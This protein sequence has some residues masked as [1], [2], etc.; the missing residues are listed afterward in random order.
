MEETYPVRTLDISKLLTYPVES[1]E[2]RINDLDLIIKN[3]YICVAANDF[4]IGMVHCL[5]QLNKWLDLKFDMPIQRRFQLAKTV[6]D[7][8]LSPG[9]VGAPFDVCYETFISLAR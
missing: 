2:R 8:A 9:L 5:R 4:H 7:I 3:L 6:Y 1:Q